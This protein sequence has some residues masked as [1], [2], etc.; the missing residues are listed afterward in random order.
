MYCG[1]NTIGNRLMACLWLCDLAWL[2]KALLPCT[3][4]PLGEAQAVC[5]LVALQ[6]AQATM[7]EPSPLGFLPTSLAQGN[8]AK[9]PNRVIMD[10]LRRRSSLSAPA[11]L[12]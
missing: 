2:C 10:I 6:A 7:K 4:A 1:A 3:T 11:A 8:T 5:F 12:G 9:Y